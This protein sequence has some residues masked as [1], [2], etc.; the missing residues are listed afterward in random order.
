MKKLINIILLF[1]TLGCNK[2]ADSQKLKS[3]SYEGYYL[4]SL[5]INED[6]TYRISL[7]ENNLIVVII[8]VKPSDIEFRNNDTINAV[9]REIING[10]YTGRYI[11]RLKS[12][13]K[14]TKYYI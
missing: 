8:S 5:Q 14:I 2:E 1:F 7:F 12:D 10:T 6:N 4:K 9:Y 3:Q 11:I 13:F